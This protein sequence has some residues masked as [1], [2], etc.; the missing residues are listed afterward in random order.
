[1]KQILGIG[2]NKLLVLFL[3]CLFF[4][5]ACSKPDKKQETDAPVEEESDALYVIEEPTVPQGVLVIDG[6][7]QVEK[8]GK[9]EWKAAISAG[10]TVDW[11]GEKKEAIL[12]YNNSKRNFYRVMT[13]LTKGVKEEFWVQEYFIY[14]PG[15]P[16]V[17]IND[18]AVLYSRPDPGAVERTG[19]VTLPKY[20]FVALIQDD[21]LTDDFIPIAAQLGLAS[22]TERWVKLKDIS[23]EA[24]VAE[25]IKLARKAASQPNVAA[26]REMLTDAMARMSM[27]SL[28]ISPLVRNDPALFELEFAGNLDLL[29]EPQD[30]MVNTDSVNVRDFPSISSNVVDQYNTGKVVTIMAR[31][32]AKTTIKAKSEDEEDMTG[33]WCRTQNGSWIFSYFL[34]TIQLGDRGTP[35]EYWD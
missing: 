20:T 31:S 26:R 15:K 35:R 27:G 21:D 30:Y 12:A 10:E 34:S 32:K 2:G 24:N 16:A 7:L 8:N 17:I 3:A 6:S 33:Q 11:T 9:M 5:C 14:G 19:K 22:T 23:W 1:M 25:G 18:D 29:A 28:S 4:V 13:E